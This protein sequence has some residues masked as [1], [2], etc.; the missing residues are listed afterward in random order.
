MA[1]DS[2]QAASLSL[3]VQLI[4]ASS[5]LLGGGYA[6][7]KFGRNSTKTDTSLSVQA[8]LIKLMKDEITELKRG[9]E[10]IGQVVT[11]MAIQNTRLSSHAQHLDLLDKQIFELRHGAGFV[12]DVNGEY[13]RG[14]KIKP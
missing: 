8:I 12:Q 7:F 5:I 2:D 13:G 4:E 9:V 1:V 10:R 6:I 3:V 11:D 14:G